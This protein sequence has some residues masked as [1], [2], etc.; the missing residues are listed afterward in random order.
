MHYYFY[1][2][3]KQNATKKELR[4][5]IQEKKENK[6]K[7]KRQQTRVTVFTKSEKYFVKG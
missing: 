2:G 7:K 4:S 6:L 3:A 5:L 1:L